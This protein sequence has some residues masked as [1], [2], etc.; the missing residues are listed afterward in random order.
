MSDRA[1]TFSITRGD[2][3]PW[4]IDLAGVQY[5]KA[6]DFREG[7]IISSLQV[8]TGKEPPRASL[9]MLVLGPHQDAPQEY[10]DKHRA[11]IDALVERVMAGRLSLVSITPSYGCEVIAL[12]ET[13]SAS[14]V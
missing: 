2:G 10:H 5:L 14:E 13:V 8:V 4:R 11:F 7:N 6:D 12:C 9:E 3:V 1:A